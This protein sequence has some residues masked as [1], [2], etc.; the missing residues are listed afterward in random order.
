MLQLSFP[1][2]SRTRT[3]LG[4]MGGDSTSSGMK[5]QQQDHAGL[6]EEIEAEGWTLDHT[7]YVFRETGSVSR[8]K[9]LSSGQTAQV[10]GE[11]VGIYVF[12]IV[13][14]WTPPTSTPA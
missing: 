3:A 14:D 10:T 8:D 7:G 1:L 11:I 12:K 6:I 5:V 4:V 9:L 2:E 13:P